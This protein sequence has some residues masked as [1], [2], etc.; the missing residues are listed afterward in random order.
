MT[1]RQLALAWRIGLTILLLVLLLVLNAL[2]GIPGA[3]AQSAGDSL[4]LA[5]YYLWYDQNTWTYDRLSDLPAEPYVSSDRGVMGRQIDQARAAGIDAFL[6]AWYGP[7]GGNPTEG[8]LAAALEEASARSFRIGILF[9][10]NS[11]FLGGSG[12]V[13]AA[14]QHA[15]S[16]HAAS[17]AFLRVDGR[18][19]IFFWRTQMYSVETWRAI[20]AQADP[21][22]AS[23]WIADGTDTSYL[24]VFDG[25]HLY[26][27]TWNPP[28]DLASVNA[29]FAAQVEQ[30]RQ[31]SGQ[32]KLW[33][34]TAMPGYNDI[35]ARGGFAQDREG[36]AYYA[37]S[38]AAA[39]ASRP[40]WVVITSFNEWPEGSYIEPSAAFGDAYLGLTA[41]Y[42]SQF[43]AG[44]GIALT[45]PAVRAAAP[46]MPSVPPS[47]PTLYVQAPLLNV[48]SGPGTEF[49]ILAMANLGAALAITGKSPQAPEWWQVNVGGTTGWVSGE[50]GQ[51][52]GPLEQVTDVETP[53]PVISGTAT[54]ATAAAAQSMPASAAAFAAPVA[55]WRPI[56]SPRP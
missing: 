18:P 35:K 33:V 22:Y 50:F 46:S 45:L 51:A 21:T 25:H 20:R 34:A 15:L 12:D 17:P 11:P 23:L 55:G 30:A 6:A 36:G 5:F 10:T 43:K 49:P 28:A 42:A 13:A 47:E 52:A 41:A 4:V 56:L 9:E 7:G 24:S 54:I 16:V 8:N 3:G 32:A 29:K 19:V 48:R 40:N 26:S 38:W 39:V 2:R 31:S 53:G 27:N 1:A 37:R 44:G 14:L